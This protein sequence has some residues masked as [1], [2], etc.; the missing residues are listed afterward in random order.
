MCSFY[1]FSSDVQCA[2]LVAFA[3]ISD[4]QKGQIFVV[5]S[6][7]GAGSFLSLFFLFN[8][9]NNLLSKIPLFKLFNSIDVSRN[10]GFSL[11]HIKFV[12]LFRTGIYSLLKLIMYMYSSS[13]ILLFNISISFIAFL[14]FLFLILVFHLNL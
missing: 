12:S 4:K 2:H 8:F 1:Y 3:L 5:G 7:T 9:L 6:G 10:S 11:S 13:S 14:S